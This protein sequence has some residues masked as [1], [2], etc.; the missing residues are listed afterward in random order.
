VTDT[1]KYSTHL[2]GIIPIA[3]SKLDF[4]M[5]WTDS[6]MPISA[7][8]HAIER[9]VNTAALAGCNTIWIV[10]HKEMQPIIKKKLGEWIYDPETIWKAPNIFFNKVEIPIYYVAVNPRDRNRRDSFAWS[11]LYGSRVVSYISRKISKWVIPKRFL[12]V[13]PYGVINDQI[14]KKAREHL[15]GPQN[16]AFTNSNLSFLDN[17]H[18]PFTFAQEEFEECKKLF[19]ERYT[20]DET[21]RTFSEVF[22]P[23]KLDN[24]VKLETDWFYD[25]SSWAKYT[26][27]IGSEHS[28]LCTRPKYMVHHEWWGLVKDK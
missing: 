15:K 8:Y 16:V 3:G 20:G 25:I 14:I 12:V 10:L 1:N 5:P 21:K 4:N 23:I 13:S 24:Y 22:E 9:A 19:R 7:N 27:F 11:S 18:L 26:Q 2:A 6:L 28:K 17:T